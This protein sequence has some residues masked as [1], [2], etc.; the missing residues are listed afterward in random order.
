MPAWETSNP[1]TS[2]P[3]PDAQHIPIGWVDTSTQAANLTPIVR[4]LLRTDV[5]R[6]GMIAGQ[7]IANH[8]FVGMPP[9]TH[10]Q[11]LGTP[12]VP[13]EDS[14][15]DPWISYISNWLA[16]GGLTAGPG[17]ESVNVD[18][19]DTSIRYL[20]WSLTATGGY[21]HTLTCGRHTPLANIFTNSGQIVDETLTSYR[22]STGELDTYRF[23]LLDDG[24]LLNSNTGHYEGGDFYGPDYG[25]TLALTGGATW[26]PEHYHDG[27]RRENATSFPMKP[28]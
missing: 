25:A 5:R 13:I 12:S 19:A 18:R 4:Q 14:G 28:A 8:W 9:F 7:V 10:S 16:S 22:R 26:P 23:Q 1:W 17:G 27:G 3:K 15:E 11:C 24:T 2:F 6:S 21:N 20:T